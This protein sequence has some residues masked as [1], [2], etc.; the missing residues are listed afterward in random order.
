[1]THYNPKRAPKPRVPTEPLGKSVRLVS[2]RPHDRVMG[3]VPDTEAEVEFI[4]TTAAGRVAVIFWSPFGASYREYDRD[5]QVK[6]V[7]REAVAP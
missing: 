5:A 2:C 4:R 1:M 3:L 6:L 7:R